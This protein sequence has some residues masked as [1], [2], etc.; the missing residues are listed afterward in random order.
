MIWFRL[1]H[2]LQRAKR[3]II[4]RLISE[5][6]EKT[7]TDSDGHRYQLKPSVG[8]KGQIQCITPINRAKDGCKFAYGQATNRCYPSRSDFSAMFHT[9]TFPDEPSISLPFV[10]PAP[11]SRDARR[12]A[13]SSA[14]L[15][16]MSVF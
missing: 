12:R 2:T 16:A 4:D 11:E 5:F 9:V 14:R 1:T 7:P 10:S 6:I 8:P 15:Y 13:T 3:P